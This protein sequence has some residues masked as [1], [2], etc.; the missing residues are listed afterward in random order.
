ML[1][2]VLKLL[3]GERGWGLFGASMFES[4]SI[5]ELEMGDFL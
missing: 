2:K 3:L 5:K 4:I 1:K